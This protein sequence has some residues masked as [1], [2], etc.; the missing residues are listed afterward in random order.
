MKPMKFKKFN[1]I[2][3]AFIPILY[4]I[5]YFFLNISLLF[6]MYL[7]YIKKNE[8]TYFIIK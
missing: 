6:C 8:Q 4:L 7:I 5:L 3:I 2:C 1:L